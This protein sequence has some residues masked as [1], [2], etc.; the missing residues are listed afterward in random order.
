MGGSG[1]GGGAG[2]VDYPDYMEDMH[3]VWLADIEQE[4]NAVQGSSP[5]TA[6][7]AYPVGSDITAY[8]GQ[9]TALAALLAGI[10]ELT[11]WHA[12]HSQ[13][14]L[15]IGTYTP[16]V[17]AD[18][19]AVADAVVG[20]VAAI[21]DIAVVDADG[22]TDAAIIAD[23]D[24]FADQLDDEIANKILPRFRRGMQDVNAVVSSSF[25]LGEACIEGFRNRDVA[26]HNSTLRVNA[27]MK[28]ADVGIA[29]MDKDVRVALGNLSKDLD[30]AKSNQL[31][32]VQI[33]TAIMNKE[34]EVAKSD[35]SKDIKVVDI[36]TRADA[37]FASIHLDGTQQILQFT[38]QNYAW[39][40]DYT[41]I[42]IESYR[43]KMVANK[44]ESEVTRE[45]EVK[46]D[47]WD[48]ELFQYGA[49]M[50]ASIGGGSMTTSGNKPSATQ[51]A[52]GGALSGAAAGAMMTP[53]NP[54][55]GGG[56]GAFLGAAAALLS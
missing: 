47:L 18:L 2:A 31:K 29:N 48:L 36:D 1:G 28:N 53:A 24:A 51:S 15:S 40:V 22:I 55:L 16:I 45:I 34:L 49:N 41:K 5:W 46:N 25:A 13:A 3:N 35:Q 17:V 14:V 52:I 56:I 11:D 30:I 6:F 32:D 23:V 7:T 19:V 12:M 27:A 10:A 38:M 42:F 4:I 44:E 43:I 20:D 39:Q 9:V 50:M 54:L 8:L 37:Q 33:E 26:R 21:A